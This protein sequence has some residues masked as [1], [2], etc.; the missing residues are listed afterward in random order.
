M[1]T[2]IRAVTVFPDRAR[3]TRTGRVQIE[4]GVQRIE[5][6]DLPLSLLPESVRA[7][8]KGTARAKLLGVSTR[9]EYFTDTPAESVRDLEAQL[10]TAQDVS[11][12]LAAH[13]GVLDKEQKYLE[14]LGAQ[15]ESFA[16]GLSLRG[17]TT[18]EQGAVFDFIRQRM[19]DIQSQ[20]LRLSREKRENDK[21]VDKLKQEL[22]AAQSARPRQR[23]VA[24][25]E[26]EVTTAGELQLDL[27]YV[28]LGASW[29]PLYDL[30]LANDTLDVTYLAQVQQNTGEEWSN[31]ALALSTAQ[32]ALSLTVP[33]LN[34]WY[35]APFVP[36]PV[37]MMARAMPAAAPMQK[38]MIMEPRHEYADAEPQMA[39][40]TVATATVSEAGAAL[41]YQLSGG[42]DVPGNGDPRKVTIA[43]FPLKPQ[44]DYVTAPKLQAACFRRAKVK[45]E[46]AYSL[47]PGG[48][49]LFEGDDF[50]GSTRMEFVAPNQEIE[51]FLGPDE[52]LRVERELAAREVDKSLLGDKRRTRFAY[53]I[54]LENLRDRP[55]LVTVRDQLPVSRDEQIKV[56]LDAADPRPT[57]HDDLNLLEWK[58]TL[59]PQQKQSVRFEFTVEHPRSLRVTGLP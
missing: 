5:V 2:T 14:A 37:P 59:E 17:K 23:Y 1:D 7:S 50:L 51:L 40:M 27:V 55:Q 57:E 53:V 4:P 30:R 34:P 6:R 26:V 20:M 31:V 47:M 12:E 11:V 58:L 52:R 3:L 56:K 45:N 24:S 28:A 33:E 22:Q 8:G 48:A 42:A 46:S 10:R 39:E 35:I 29:Q 9:M 44:L 16:R 15:A 25:V 54:K 18:E 36:V 41:T 38:A 43:N 32:P 19:T 21:L 13:S 49:Q